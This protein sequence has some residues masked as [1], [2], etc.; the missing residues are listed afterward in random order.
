MTHARTGRPRP[1][2]TAALALLILVPALVGFATKFREFLALVRFEEGA[3]TIVPILNYLLVGMGFLLLFLWA[4]LHG[5]FRDV[6]RP[7]FT[8]LANERRLDAELDEER[9]AQE[10]WYDP[11]R[12]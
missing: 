12:A 2:V 1:W 8:M 7:K 10:E 4:M 11:E 5:M 6:E 3:F 9:R